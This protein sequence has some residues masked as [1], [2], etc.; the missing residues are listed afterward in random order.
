[1]L[2]K[3]L[4]SFQKKK[5]DRK[6]K[7]QNQKNPQSPQKSQEQLNLQN[8]KS[9]QREKKKNEKE[10]NLTPGFNLISQFQ[11][12]YVVPKYAEKLISL[13]RKFIVIVSVV[14][15]ILLI[16]NFVI[17]YVIQF[18]KDWQEEL[19]REID[20]YAGVEEKAKRI[21]DKT[22]L[23]KKFSN[24][25]KLLSEKLNYVL[26]NIGPDV[27]LEDVQMDH[28]GFALSLSG[29]S[30]LDFT[31]LIVRY[32]EGNMLSEIVIVSANFDKSEN[33][34]NVRID[35]VFR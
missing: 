32:L 5:N 27:I 18:Q 26:D 29:K 33:D 15:G 25:R 9:P 31:N 6:Q 3:F 16:F 28:L 20:S 19:V 23:Y 34:F 24:D 12:F 4:P 7:L 8:P 10:E 1:M 13:I 11:D 30:A 21:S 2:E 22:F 14:F 17:S 35:G